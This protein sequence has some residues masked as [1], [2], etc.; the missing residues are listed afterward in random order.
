L[1]YLQG[2]ARR[3]AALHG[4]KLFLDAVHAYDQALALDPADE[5]LVAARRQSSFALAFEAE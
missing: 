5:V 2:H 1:I 3:A 4:L